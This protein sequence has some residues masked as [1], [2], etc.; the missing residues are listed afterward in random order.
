MFQ[1]NLCLDSMMLRKSQDVQLCPLSLGGRVRVY[2]IVD[3]I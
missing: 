1:E 3:D 2:M